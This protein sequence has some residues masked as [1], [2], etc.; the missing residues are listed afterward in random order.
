M[1]SAALGIRDVRRSSL[2]EYRGPK[3]SPAPDQRGGER[4][5]PRHFC[6]WPFLDGIYGERSKATVERFRWVRAPT[7]AELTQVAHA[8]VRR[9]GC[10]IGRR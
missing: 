2:S 9:V 10:F 6:H 3:P 4:Q 8:I 1:G 7:P 5:R